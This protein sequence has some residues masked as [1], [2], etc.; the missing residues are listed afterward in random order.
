M[1][2]VASMAGRTELGK[3]AGSLTVLYHNNVGDRRYTIL[4]ASATSTSR[5]SNPRLHSPLN[6]S[7]YSLLKPGRIGEVM[8]QTSTG[9][10]SHSV[11][12]LAFQESFTFRS[13]P[14]AWF[15]KLD[16]NAERLIVPLEIVSP[17]QI[18][19]SLA[20]EVLTLEVYRFQYV[21]GC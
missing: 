3:Q 10:H 16:P 14:F 17:P 11:L 19:R 4:L 18:R 8:P 7:S 21:G 12:L 15:R 5:V 6:P 13:H 9:T 1:I 20:I 2:T